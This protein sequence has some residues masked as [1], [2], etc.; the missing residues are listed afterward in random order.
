MDSATPS[1][2][3]LAAVGLLRL[4]A[5][6]GDERYRHHAEAILRLAGPLAAQHPNAFGYLLVAVDL[7]ANGL[8][9]IVVAGDRPDLVRVVHDRF[10]PNAVLAWGERFDSPLWEDRQDGR[11]YVCRNYACQLPADDEAVLVDQ[12]AA[13]Q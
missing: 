1:A 13:T 6:T 11:A 5:L 4:A 9:E 10:L 7:G 2:N 12:L 3:S 8:D